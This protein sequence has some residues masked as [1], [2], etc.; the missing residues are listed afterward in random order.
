MRANHER[1][2]RSVSGGQ[3]ISFADRESPASAAEVTERPNEYAQTHTKKFSRC[4][5]GLGQAPT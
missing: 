4:P 2:G 3:M 1:A 5:L